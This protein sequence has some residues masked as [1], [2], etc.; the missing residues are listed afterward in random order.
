MRPWID[1]LEQFLKQALGSRYRLRGVTDSSVQFIYNSQIEVDLLLS[2]KW[3]SLKEFF[4]FLLTIPAVH[5][6][7]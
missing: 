7:K 5:R 2:P 4:G 1:Q 3:A 6:M